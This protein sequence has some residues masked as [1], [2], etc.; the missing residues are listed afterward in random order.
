MTTQSR[1]SFLRGV[2]VLF[3][4]LI[5]SGVFA[6][7]MLPAQTTGIE[8]SNTQSL[9]GEQLV[10][11]QCEST[12]LEVASYVDKI[13]WGVVAS[14]PLRVLSA[15]RN[16]KGFELFQIKSSVSGYRYILEVLQD[17]RS[18]ACIILSL[19]SQSD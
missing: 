9:L 8:T 18:E 2:S 19:N 4:T 14:E 17:E 5:G 6:F 12:A 1:F 10:A 7:Q 11:V 15:T 3:L 13:G 16:E